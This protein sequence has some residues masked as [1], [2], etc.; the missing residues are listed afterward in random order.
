MF[1]KYSQNRGTKF[2]KKVNTCFELHFFRDKNHAI[3]LISISVLSTLT[4]ATLSGLQIFPD[5]L[6][7]KGFGSCC[8]RALAQ[9]LKEEKSLLLLQW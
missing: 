1:Q 5:S 7:L 3:L 9:T 2:I 4:L 6:S 8:T